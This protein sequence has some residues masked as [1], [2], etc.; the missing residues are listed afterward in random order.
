MSETNIEE[1]LSPSIEPETDSSATDFQ[2]F[3]PRSMKLHRIE[4]LIAAAI[5]G[6]VFIIA[7]S[8][9]FAIDE[10]PYWVTLIVIVAGLVPISLLMWA[11]SRWP[12]LAYENYGWR[13][14]D[15][16][17]QVRH[18][19]FWRHQLSI[20]IAR[21]QH[22]DVSQGPLE[23]RYGLGTLTIHTAGTHQASVP[24]TSFTH[25]TAIKLRDQLV[26]QGRSGHVV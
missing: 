16:G 5:V 13:L 9:L 21:V 23:R 14:N 12:R 1:T 19:V 4:L 11:A 8:I 18:G 22:A 17:L 6:A 20:P 24:L 15:I 2:K 7:A 3:D 10:V 25:E 26:A